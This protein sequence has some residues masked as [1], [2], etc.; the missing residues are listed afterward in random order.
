MAK[1]EVHTEVPRTRSALYSLHESVKDA[2]GGVQRYTS[3][4]NE[5]ETQP[6]EEVFL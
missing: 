6:K 5:E 3:F 4:R 1:K 2:A